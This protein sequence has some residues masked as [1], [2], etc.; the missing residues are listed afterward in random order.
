MTQLYALSANEIARRVAARTLSATEVTEAALARLDAVN[1]AIN[2]VVKPLHEEA[3]TAAAALD[4]AL[5][6]GESPGL[7]AGVPITI[8]VNTDQAGHATT[9]GLV[10]QRD[11]VAAQDNPVVANLR[12]A[13]A[14][15]VGRT[16]T[17]AF[18]LRW[19]TSNN[20]HGH[21]RNPH[22]PS[23]TPGGSSGGAAAATAAGIGA[24]GHG[25]DIG[26]SVRYP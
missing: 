10:T 16:N 5:A 20:L 18:S 3:R 11:H 2:A 26:G 13:G 24:I 6:R 7:L 25:T 8:K 17:P 4:A 9:N 21:T 15:I 14:I 19:F 12:R 22:D 23:I 1:P